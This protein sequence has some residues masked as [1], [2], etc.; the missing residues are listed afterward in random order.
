M[1]KAKA[2]GKPGPKHLNSKLVAEM[3]EVAGLG[4]FVVSYENV[5]TV[6]RALNHLMGDFLK[7]GVTTG[8]AALGLV[9]ATR[10]FCEIRIA[11]LVK[12]EDTRERMASRLWNAMTQA[13]REGCDAYLLDG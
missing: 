10:Y 6:R 7:R 9:L 5:D 8:D 4:N 3:K 1:R 2:K 12:E 11:D 13:I